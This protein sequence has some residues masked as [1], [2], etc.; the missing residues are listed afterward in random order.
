MCVGRIYVL[1]HDPPRA[2]WVGTYI[3]IASQEGGC[4]CGVSISLIVC[5]VG[6]ENLV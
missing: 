3:G 2:R 5:V 6:R 1:S 4:T